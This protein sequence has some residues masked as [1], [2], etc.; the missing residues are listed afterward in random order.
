MS[1]DLKKFIKNEYIPKSTIRYLLK[2][3]ENEL[4][5]LRVMFQ[6]NDFKD[7]QMTIKIDTIKNE[8]TFIKDI[9]KC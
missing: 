1:E 9:L 3:K 5:D 8:I 7:E 6:L 4:Q 2:L